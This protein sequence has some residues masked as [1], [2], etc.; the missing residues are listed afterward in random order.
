MR[1]IIMNMTHLARKDYGNLLNGTYPLHIDP[2]TDAELW[3]SP[4]SLFFRW[5][6]EALYG[7]RILDFGL[8]FS[9]WSSTQ[10]KMA[11]HSIC[12]A[13]LTDV[14]GELTQKCFME[15]ASIQYSE[16][17]IPFHF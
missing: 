15:Q 13:H 17:L 16:A 14:T 3:P 10:S 8:E 5:P 7:W 6:L 9:L 12:G 1:T 11:Q 4:F 2:T